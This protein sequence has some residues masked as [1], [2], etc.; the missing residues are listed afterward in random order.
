[1]SDQDNRQQWEAYIAWLR[2]R[3]LD[4]PMP[5]KPERVG[6]AVVKT[7][8]ELTA[9]SVEPWLLVVGDIPED[10]PEEAR[11]FGASEWALLR[12]TLSSVGID[13]AA[14]V[15]AHLGDLRESETRPSVESID[16]RLRTFVE[17]RTI[18]H[19][20]ALGGRTAE[21]LLDRGFMESRGV[22]SMCARFERSR[23][24]ATLHPRDVLRFVGYTPIWER[25]VQMIVDDRLVEGDGGGK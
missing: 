13:D 19:V 18:T 4:T 5:W 22:F 16:D 20:L 6:S 14:F 17:S 7:G 21:W 12:N 2:D 1:M 3:G 8:D 25:A 23:V 9:K 24:M 15:V 10:G 11:G